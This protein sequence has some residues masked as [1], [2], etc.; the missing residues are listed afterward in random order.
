MKKFT[1][2]IS[3]IIVIV[4]VAIAGFFV[5]KFYFLPKQ[6]IKKQSPIFTVIMPNFTDPTLNKNQTVQSDGNPQIKFTVNGFATSPIVIS[7]NDSVNIA[8]S[9]DNSIKC[10]YSE[11]PYFVPVNVDTM[12]SM[13]ESSQTDDSTKYII[14]CSNIY[15]SL[16][17]S[18]I[19]NKK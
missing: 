16:S 10:I 18:I 5:H 17:K 12:G 8:W 2:I 14:T 1:I 13:F 15:G 6:I 7:S 3:I 11:S 19:A 4:I 9:S